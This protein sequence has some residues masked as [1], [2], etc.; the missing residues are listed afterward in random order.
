MF[1]YKEETRTDYNGNKKTVKVLREGRALGAGFLAIILLITILSSVRF[2]GTGQ[3][4]VVTQY[5]KVTGRELGEGAHLVAPWGINRITKYDVKVQKEENEAAA[6]SRDLQ[7]VNA[8]VV[9]NYRLNRGNVSDIHKTVGKDFKERLILPAISESFKASSSSFTASEMITKRNEVKKVAY[10]ATKQ[11]LERYGIVVEDLSITNFSFSK[12]FTKAIEAKQVAQQEAE[13]AK[14]N[15][16]KAENNANA[17]VAEAEG[18]AKAQ[19]ILRQN[20]TSEILQ[21]QAIEKWDGK[22]PQYLGGNSVFNIPLR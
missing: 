19:R 21:K 18:Q 9:V 13:Q 5:G 16:E 22:L 10:E 1:F 7:D 17:A 4:G 6:A 14:Y 20:L 11:R 12:E 15:V 2:V 3:V 8:T